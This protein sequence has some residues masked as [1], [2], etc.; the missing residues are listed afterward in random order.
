MIGALIYD[1]TC[2]MLPAIIHAKVAG[3]TALNS[4]QLLMLF[5]NLKL[6]R[7]ITVPSRV[8]DILSLGTSFWF[9]QSS[10]YT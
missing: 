3:F 10:H 5:G 6:S 4:G 8:D 9:V 1:E 2:C 7:T